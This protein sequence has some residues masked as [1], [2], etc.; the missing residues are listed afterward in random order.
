MVFLREIAHLDWL[1]SLESFGSQKARLLKLP[2]YQPVTDSAMSEKPRELRKWSENNTSS[3]LLILTAPTPHHGSASLPLPQ[4]L[5]A[6]G[7]Q[8]P[9]VGL[10]G[11]SICFH[12]ATRHF[13]LNDLEGYLNTILCWV[14]QD[15]RC[16]SSTLSLQ[17]WLITWRLQGLRTFHR[18]TC[19][20][21]LIRLADGTDGCWAL[22][23]YYQ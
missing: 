17:S 9:C 16:I 4:G 10:T 12:F 6:A 8:A 14:P 18:R 21:V 20:Q 13:Y 3:S 19:L 5:Q 15:R 11:F 22:S 1:M 2:E 7:N 23:A